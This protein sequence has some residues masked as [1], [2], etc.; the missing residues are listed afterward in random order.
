MACGWAAQSRSELNLG[1]A[2]GIAVHEFLTASGHV[3]YAL[4][5]GR[6]LHGVI[7][8]KPQGTTLSGFSEKAER[9]IA[10][11]S[12]HLVREH[13]QVRFEYVSSGT[14]IIFR[15]HVDPAPA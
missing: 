13:A 2:L 4:F 15:D 9:Y 1:A 8:A 5:V 12:K 7:E 3:D 10:D 11:V 14:E 6:K